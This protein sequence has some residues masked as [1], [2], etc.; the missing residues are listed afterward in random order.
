V[1]FPLGRGSSNSSLAVQTPGI[2]KVRFFGV[3]TN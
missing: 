2:I 3:Y 1:K